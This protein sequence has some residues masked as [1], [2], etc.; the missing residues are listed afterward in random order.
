[1]EDTIPLASSCNL[2]EADLSAADLSGADLSEAN[3]SEANLT[4]AGTEAKSAPASEI[5][6][7]LFMINP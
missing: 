4:W 5:R 2:R 6:R 3:L 1:M 7:N